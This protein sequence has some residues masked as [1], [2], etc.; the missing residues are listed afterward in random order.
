M[1]TNCARTKLIFSSSKLSVLSFRR[2]ECIILTQNL[3]FI[4][5]FLLYCIIIIQVG[6]RIPFAE[7]VTCNKKSI[8][9]I[10]EFNLWFLRISCIRQGLYRFLSPPDSSSPFVRISMKLLVRMAT[11][12]FIIIYLVIRIH[13][14][15]ARLIEMLCCELTDSH[16]IFDFTARH[17]IL[18]ARN[19]VVVDTKFIFKSAYD[20][21][22]GSRG[23]CASVCVHVSWHNWTVESCDL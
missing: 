19:D 16:T 22:N 11:I 15:I 13:A 10:C 18:G 12:G 9:S 23:V 14:T 1:N 2:R 5:L 4:A 8:K 3:H 17:S 21:V 7:L 20:T 6:S